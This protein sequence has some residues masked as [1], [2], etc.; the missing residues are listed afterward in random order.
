MLIVMEFGVGAKPLSVNTSNNHKYRLISYI[1]LKV[2]KA[3][4]KMKMG[5]PGVLSK[6]QIYGPR[7]EKTH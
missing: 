4:R 6:V 3:D 1:S 5:Y 2:V 7:D